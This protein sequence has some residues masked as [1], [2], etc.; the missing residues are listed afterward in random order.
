MIAA[1]LKEKKI[2]MGDLAL[3]WRMWKEENTLDDES[4]ERYDT[5]Q[6]LF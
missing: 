5:L 3:I 6:K 2:S 1:G 4:K